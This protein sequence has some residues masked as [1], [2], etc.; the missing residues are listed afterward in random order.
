MRNISE[1]FFLKILIFLK[2]SNIM[3]N[4][5][6]SIKIIMFVVNWISSR[7]IKFLINF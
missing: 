3:K 6:R 2:I 4:N 5:N 7:N 1:K